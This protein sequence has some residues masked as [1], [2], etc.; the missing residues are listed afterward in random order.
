MAG[1]GRKRKTRRSARDFAQ[2]KDLKAKSYYL[3]YELS[4]L[5]RCTKNTPIFGEGLKE[6]GPKSIFIRRG[7]GAE[8]KELKAKSYYL[9]Y[10]LSILH[11]YAPRPAEGGS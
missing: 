6:W 5:H 3:Y 1:I 10:E 7:I 2:M 4:I 9:Y 11:Y 8:E